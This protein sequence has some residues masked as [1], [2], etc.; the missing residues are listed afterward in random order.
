MDKFLSYALQKVICSWSEGNNHE[1]AKKLTVILMLFVAS[2]WRGMRFQNK[3]LYLALAFADSV[4][5][6]QRRNLK[7]RCVNEN[8]DCYDQEEGDLFDQVI[9]DDKDDILH[10]SDTKDDEHNEDG[11]PVETIQ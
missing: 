8:L 9:Q 5:P 4:F 10:A 11:C 1:L 2:A 7:I 6:M 3:Q